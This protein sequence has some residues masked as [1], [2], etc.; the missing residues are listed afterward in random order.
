MQDSAAK[1]HELMEQTARGNPKAFATVASR[2]APALWRFVRAMTNDDATASDVVQDALLQAFR[3][4]STY[5]PQRGPLKP[6]LF[7]IAR[8]EAHRS[9]RP[10]TA[11]TAVAAVDDLPLELLGERA[12]WGTET[13]EHQLQR[14]EQAERLSWAIASL[15]AADR[16]VLILRDVDGLSGQDAAEVLGVDL[17]SMKSRLHR[18]RLRLL[19]AVREEETAMNAVERTEGG[20]TCRQVLEQLSDYVDGHLV[21]PARLRIEE[22]FRRCNVCERFGG[23]FKQVV[24]A[25]RTRLGAAPAVDEQTYRK[26]LAHWLPNTQVAPQN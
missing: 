8:H 25:V 12:G 5:N 23:H 9:A 7:A 6:W 19:A 11:S 15:S 3:R 26:L 4:A 10:P 14:A 2:Y 16:A 17:A 20:L 18:A 1:D 13:P 24:V 22:H 21:E